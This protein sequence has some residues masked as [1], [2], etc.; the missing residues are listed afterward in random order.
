MQRGDL[1]VLMRDTLLCTLRHREPIE[2]EPD[3]YTITCFEP[4]T[5]IDELDV[6]C[7][8]FVRIDWLPAIYAG[9]NSMSQ[10]WH[11]VIAN[12]RVYAVPHQH[13]KDARVIQGLEDT[14]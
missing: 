14:L 9:P 1:I 6:E 2:I 7:A 11:D 3:Q 12:G 10:S 5:Y 4:E 8:D 13:M